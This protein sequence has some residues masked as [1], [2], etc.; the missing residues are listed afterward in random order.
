MNDEEYHACV[1]PPLSP[2][3]W[4]ELCFCFDLDFSVDEISAMIGVQPT[5]AKR[6]RECSWNFYEGIQNPGYWMLEFCK[7][8]TFDSDEV[9]A[10]MHSFIEEHR[11]KLLEV[12]ERFKPNTTF[13]R[14]YTVVHQDGEYPAIRLEPL[15]IR[16]AQLLNAS[17]DI[18]LENDY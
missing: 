14:I 12:V 13:L 3:M 6:R 4:G 2:T 10:V 15:F 1:L 17:I 16:D 5:K 8:D 18:I 7:T 9:Q 11:N